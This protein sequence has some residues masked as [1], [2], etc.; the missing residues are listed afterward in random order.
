MLVH[1]F[2]ISVAVRG[3][4][5][6]TARC[7]CRVVHIMCSIEFTIY[8]GIILKGFSISSGLA[9]VIFQS[10]RVKRGRCRNGWPKNP[11]RAN[12][13]V[14]ITIIGLEKNVEERESER[15]RE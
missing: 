12:D 3:M 7:M 6:A 4:N 10:P 11:F 9:S 2:T 5:S 8:G 15:E 14:R 1:D 13:G